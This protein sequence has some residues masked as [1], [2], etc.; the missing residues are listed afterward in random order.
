MDIIQDYQQRIKKFIWAGDLRTASVAKQRVIQSLRICY[1]VARDLIDGQLTLRAMGLVYTTLLSMVPF[2][3]I[4]FSVLK[5]FGVHNQIEPMMLNFLEPLGEKGIEITERVLE[6]VDNMKAGVLGSVGLVLLIYTAVSLMQKIESTFNYMWHVSQSRPLAQRFSDYLSVIL[7]GPVLIFTALG[8]TASIA[9]M[10]LVQ[11]LMEI[12]AIGVA[13]QLSSRL[14]PYVLV[15]AAFTMVYLLVPNTKVH[16]KAALLGGVVAGILWQTA[17]I[18]FASFVVNS[19]K[20]TAIYSV[21]ASLIFFMI[22]LY[23]SW[24]ILLIGCGI[25]FYFQ[26]P[27]HR[28]LQSR[29]GMLSSRMKEKIA[30]LVMALIGNHYYQSKPV[31]TVDALAKQLKVGVY[32]CD[33]I[34]SALLHANILLKTDGDN[35]GL[36]PA[37]APETL[38]VADIIAAV[39]SQSEVAAFSPAMLP[40]LESVESIFPSMEESIANSL[41]GKTLKDLAQFTDPVSIDNDSSADSSSES[42]SSAKVQS[43]YDGAKQN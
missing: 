4:S 17:G 28:H 18:V 15:I 25:A 16:F 38:L 13:V 36:L 14:V 26:H 6:F 40:K 5:G 10:S 29:V 7:I 33:S 21:F 32:A 20:Y 3:A 27:E 35:P 22:W 31:W 30:L 24:L 2:I 9:S 23:I 8:I 41:Q 12:Q 39:R 42:N 43:L 34:I 11:Q 1:L 37:R 19:A